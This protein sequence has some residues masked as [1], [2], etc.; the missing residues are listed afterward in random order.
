MR[1]L[2]LLSL[3][4]F[5]TQYVLASTR[6]LNTGNGGIDL[7][8]RT[9]HAAVI[10]RNEISAGEAG[11]ILR[12][13][14]GSSDEISLISP[15]IFLVKFSDRK[16]VEAI[17]QFGLIVTSAES[18][19]KNASLT[20]Y[21]SSMKVIQVASDKLIA[22]LRNNSDLQRFEM[23]NAELGCT[24]EG[25]VNGSLGFLLK[26]NSSNSSNVLD[27]CEEYY[28]SGIFE[29]V[30]PE[31]IYPGGKLLHAVPNDQF[32]SHQWALHN[33][34]QLIQT[35]STFQ[36]FGDASSVYG[37]P[38]SD[39]DLPEAWDLTSGSPLI[40]IGVIDSGID[41]AHADLQ[42]A[43]HLLAGYDAFN[44]RNGSAVDYFN[45]GTSVAGIIGAVNNNGIGVAGVAPGCRLMSICIFDNNGTTSTTIITR[46]FDTAVARGIDI[47]TNSWGGG[48]SEPAITDA[49]N[50]AAN[51][52]RGGLGCPVFFSAGNDGKN[53]PVYPSVLPNVICIGSSTPHDQ[54]KSPGTGNQFYWGSNY[55]ENSTGDL[56]AIAPTNCYTLSSGGYNQYFTGTSASASFGAGIAALMLSVD[57]SQTRT[58]VYSD[59][60]RACEKPDNADYNL[61][62]AFGKWNVHYGYGRLNAHKAVSLA[63]GIDASGPVIS[64]ANVSSHS[65]TYPTTIVAKITDHD[66]GSVPVTGQNVPRIH[67]TVKKG[68][69]SWSAYDSSAAYSVNGSSFQFRIPSLGWDSEVKYF[70]RAY[71]AAGNR[72]EFPLHAPAAMNLC[73]Y[74]VGNITSETG[75]VPA[76]S[77]ADYGGTISPAINFNAFTIVDAKMKVNMRHTYLQEELFQVYAPSTDPNNNRKCL[78]SG[79]GNDGDNIYGASVSDSASS[80][81]KDGQPPYLNGNFKPEFP[82]IGL[83]GM[84]AGGAWRIVHFDGGIGD[85]ALFDSVRITLYRTNGTKSPAIRLNSPADSTL[86]FEN[87][88]FPGVYEKNFYLKNSG[89]STLTISAYNFTGQ[90]SSMYSLLNTPPSSLAAGDSGLF[91]V[92]LNTTVGSS[93]VSQAILNIS[94]NDPSK[95]AFRVSMVTVDSLRT[96]LKNL[97]LTALVQGFYNP[98]SNLSVQDTVTVFLRRFTSPYAIV[99][100]ARGVLSSSGS[101]SFNFRNVQ[102]GTSYYIMVRHRSAL[103]TWSSV[104]L[105]YSG[106]QASYNFTASASAAYGQNQ[107]LVGT[108]YCLYS[109]DV[110]TDYLIDGA[111]VLSVDNAASG[112]MT[113][114][115]RQDVN[116]DGFVDATDVGITDRNSENFVSAIRP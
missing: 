18:A 32:F 36:T 109:G 68:N 47:L 112:Y 94:T 103:E 2:V 78:F 85:Y 95:P 44:N 91:R 66:G 54:K 26:M 99:D 92:R 97:Q 80:Y 10:M 113:G 69:G 4:F 24:V 101:G 61:S 21:G 42:S 58:D 8:P 115:V 60:L 35:G 1:R 75:K 89:N 22:K 110:N 9:D 105:V 70:L 27:V 5:V 3:L 62:K 12:P 49:I 46:A 11:R 25:N 45:H 100:S 81:W 37:L 53:P 16:T 51:N 84:N 74:A 76:F 52:G 116:G 104:P 31:F 88:S 23:L 98:V 6:L 41:S 63:L 43:G 79:N 50:N 19:V 96:G 73:F 38:D 59:L 83:R 28:L 30:Q 17:E 111:D 93:S 71:D 15:G 107:I 7:K 39:M 14:L 33:S 90:Q 13:Y 77:G 56:D 64:H 108:R 114:Y 48:T 29:Y 40:K 102:S 57:Q 20:F 106:I 87:S 65:S 34:G 82:L 67:Y 86:L 72:T 55:G